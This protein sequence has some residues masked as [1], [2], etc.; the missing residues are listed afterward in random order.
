MK[1]FLGY[2]R[3]DGGVGVR[4]YVAI[5]STVCCANPVVEKVAR[6]V[7]GS[8]GLLHGH[9]CGRRPE[10]EMHNMCLKG[11][12]TNPN[13]YGVVVVALGCEGTPYKDVAADIE[14]TGRP[15]E[16]V[17]IQE[18][19][20]IKATEK[21]IE[22]AK[23]MVE[24]AKKEQRSE[25]PVSELMVGMEC[26]GSDAL[27]GVTSNPSI[28][29][30][31]DWLVSEGATTILTETTEL[32]GTNHIL[33]RRAA[34]EEVAKRIDEVIDAAQHNVNVCLGEFAARAISPGN[35]DG[36][37]STIQEKA[38]GCVRKGGSS[39]INE[40]VDYGKKPTKKGLII[41]EGPGFDTESLGGMASMGCQIMF[42][43]TGRGNPIG[44]PIVPVI[45]VGSNTALYERMK[46]DIDVNAGKII[47]DNYSFDQLKE[48]MI[49]LLIRVANGEQSK[50][51][52]NEQGGIVCFWSCSK[53]L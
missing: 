29:N 37:M 33:K 18:A 51:E 24:E 5:L 26:G 11:L 7:P 23:R 50:A 42:F 38:L 4:N 52:K 34:N 6:A 46:D 16:L 22:A 40:V 45:K 32:I 28:G 48:E 41:M 21:A 36:G 30:I 9:G 19:G 43:S 44:F 12:G 17:V 2:K 35:M 1:T 31:S 15:V 27:S 25:F 10:R 13:I 39:T 3:K 49:D 8:V 47:T 20:S 14:K 53:S